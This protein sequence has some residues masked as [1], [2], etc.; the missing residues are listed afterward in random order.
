VH[1]ERIPHAREICQAYN[2]Y[3]FRAERD[4]KKIETARVHHQET[5]GEE[6]VSDDSILELARKHCLGADD[7]LSQLLSRYASHKAKDSAFTDQRA[8]LQTIEEIASLRNRVVELKNRNTKLLSQLQ[9]Y[10]A[11]EY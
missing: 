2:Y 10:E 4:V 8:L 7:I 11:R 6:Q 1:P 5:Q 9:E 3:R